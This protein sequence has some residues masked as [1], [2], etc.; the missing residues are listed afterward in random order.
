MKKLITTVRVTEISD[1]SVRLIK[2]YKEERLLQKEAF[3]K[4]L[5]EELEI[6]S[7]QI[8]EA[9]KRDIL[10][11]KQKEA[12]QRRNELIRSFNTALIGYRSLP[13]TTLKES[14]EKLYAVFSKYGMKIIKENYASKSSLIEA[15]LKDLSS[16]ELKTPI[17]SLSGIAEIISGLRAE[18]TAFTA[19]RLSYETFRAKDQE[20]VSASTLKKPTLHLIN[21]KLIPFLFGMKTANPEEYK[22]FCEV[23]SQIIEKANDAIKKRN[24]GSTKK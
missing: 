20:N 6:L 12:D 13:V 3:L 7:Q 5:F 9:I 23:V 4:S 11:S 19:V 22:A 10:P 18:Q 8:I 21:S 15:L 17:E 1:I 2:V 14:A 24:N 16:P